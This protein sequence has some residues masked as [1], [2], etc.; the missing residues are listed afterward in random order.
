MIG[1]AVKYAAAEFQCPS[2]N[3]RGDCSTGRTLVHNNATVGGFITARR[4]WYEVY[5]S[6][7]V[8]SDQARQ[9]PWVAG[10]LNRGVRLDSFAIHTGTPYNLSHFKGTRQEWYGKVGRLGDEAA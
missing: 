6:C 3:Q 4:G 7:G 8:A 10:K 5:G 2:G 1:H 9:G